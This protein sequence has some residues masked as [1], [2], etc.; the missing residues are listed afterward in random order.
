MYAAKCH[1]ELKGADVVIT[2]VA[3]GSDQK[4][5]HDMSVYFPRFVRLDLPQR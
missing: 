3:N 5:A 4:L 1:A 2:Y